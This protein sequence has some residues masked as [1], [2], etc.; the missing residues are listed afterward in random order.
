MTGQFLKFILVGGLAAV[1]NL[2]ARYGFSRLMSFEWAVAA[3]FPLGLLTAFV[4][5]R[6]LV[7]K[8]SGRPM[9]QEFAWFLTINLAALVQ[10]WLISV[11]LARWLFPALK[12]TYYPLELAHFV[13]VATPMITSYLGHKYLTFRQVPS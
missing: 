9:K 12:F 8:S 11:G 6:K 4:L 10:V 3:A 2:V 1:V 7:F 13:G 5:S